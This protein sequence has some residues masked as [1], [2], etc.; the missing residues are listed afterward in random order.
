[1]TLTQTHALQDAW[2]TKTDRRCEHETL[3]LTRT[4]SG[5]ITGDYACAQCGS[6]VRSPD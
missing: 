1:M 4:P 6:N 5:Y 3:H 2:D